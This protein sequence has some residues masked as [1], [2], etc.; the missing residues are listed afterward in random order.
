MGSV[1]GCG[2]NNLNDK[3]KSGGCELHERGREVKLL[4]TGGL[5]VGVIR[6]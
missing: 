2:W 4:E 5:Q 3:F 6:G 1:K